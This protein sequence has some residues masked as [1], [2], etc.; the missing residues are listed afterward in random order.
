MQLNVFRVRRFLF[1]M[2]FIHIIF[3]QIVKI[4]TIFYLLGIDFSSFL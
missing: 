1:K 3:R 2:N 4:F